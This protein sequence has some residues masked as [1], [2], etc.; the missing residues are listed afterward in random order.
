[1]KLAIVMILV[2][3]VVIACGRRKERAF[4]D[5]EPSKPR[6]AKFHPPLPPSAFHVE[7]TPVQLSELPAGGS[8][9]VSV[10]F[11]NTSDATWP[12]AAMADPARKS[13][14]YAVRLSYSWREKVAGAKIVGSGERVNLAK[15]LAPGETTT[16]PIGVRAPAK[17]GQYELIFDLVQELCCWFSSHG[18]DPLT[19]PVEVRPAGAASTQTSTL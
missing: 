18:A 17:P 6:P 7:W 5:H 10:T 2:L 1:M 11:K 13:G 16:L 12:D 4:F 14:S 15:P 19:V 8:T 9:V 3:A